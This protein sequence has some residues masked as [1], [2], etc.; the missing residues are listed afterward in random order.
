M[1]TLKRS[2]PGRVARFSD[3]VQMSTR[4]MDTEVDVENPAWC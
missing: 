2:F 4:T 3:R 1:P